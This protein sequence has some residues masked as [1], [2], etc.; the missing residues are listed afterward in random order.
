MI[1]LEILLILK[2]LSDIGFTK[3]F[4]INFCKNNG[5]KFQ[6]CPLANFEKV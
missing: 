5:A 3:L 4:L 6:L 2:M 1:A